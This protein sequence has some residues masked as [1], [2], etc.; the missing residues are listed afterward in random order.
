MADS[1]GASLSYGRT[2]VGALLL[3]RW[4]RRNT[5]P[6]TPL[7]AGSEPHL[8]LLLPSSV[9]GALAN[10]AATFAGKVVV[11]LNFTAGAEAMAI[12]IER[13]GIR[14]IL[15]SRAFIAK[16]GIPTDDCMVFLEDVMKT[17]TTGSKA[18]TLV[19]AF[20]LPARA[21]NRFLIARP[22]ADS[23]ATVVFSSGS[24]GIPK[25]VM[26]THRNILANVDAVQQVFDV[27]PTDVMLGV[28]PFFHS[29]GFTGTLW[30][31]IVSGFAVVY[32][33]NPTDAKTIGELAEKHRATMLISTPTFCSA[34]VR[35]C[36]P[37]QFSHLRYAMVG[38]E[39]LREPVAAAFKE[40]FGLALLE[41]YGCT[42]MSPIV[43]VN[44][45]DV[46]SDAG[47]QRGT[48]AGTVGHPLPGVAAKIVDATTGEGPIFDREGLLLVAGPNRMVGYLREE[49]R[50][51]EVVRDG[52]YVTGDIAA[53]DEDG[54]IRI[55]DPPLA[56]QQDRRARWC[57][58]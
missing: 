17:F 43:A 35:K 7:G 4:M 10:I 58:T 50:T 49:D 19:T 51:R 47:L 21:I 30:F 57:R 24:T 33:P 55:T 20:V 29:F 48:R 38:A 25:G 56:F 46:T 37:E 32:H 12:A 18:V 45:P 13:C 11:N 52:W 41:G 6:S 23:L 40:K 3:A 5:G 34:Y 31:P 8:G 1:T 9:G 28:L 42:E 16:A 27:N 36:K 53:I 22:E 15:T 54:F 39:K 2:L 26:L 44:R 14:T